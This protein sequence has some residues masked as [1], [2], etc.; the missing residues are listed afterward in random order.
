[1]E[2]VMKYKVLLTGKNKII[3]DDFF[4]Q[5]NEEFETVSTSERFED[6]SNHL[7]FFQPDAFVC[8]LHQESNEFFNRI[9]SIKEQLEKYNTTLVVIG[10]EGDCKA[11]S[12]YAVNMADLMLQKPITAAIVNTEIWKFLEIKE[13]RRQEQE[14]I[15]REKREKEEQERLAREEAENRKH[16]LIVDDDPLMLKLIKE[17]LH[18][19]YNVG[20]ATSGKT[21]M[22]FLEKKHTDLILLDYKMPDEDGPAVFEK[23][24]AN[25]STKDTPVVFLTGIAEREKITKAL[26]LKPQGYLVKPV[27]N[28]KLMDTIQK[29]IG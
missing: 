21:A 22:K 25:E 14:R 23:I 9:I 10:A 19:D 5:M 13:R 4:T 24:R 1:M 18:E 6:I 15:E 7:K 8:C 12:A 11:F 3:I 27:D 16:I 29:I 17:Y 28:K 26:I 2:Y 20:T